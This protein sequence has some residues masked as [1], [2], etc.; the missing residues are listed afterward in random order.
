MARQDPHDGWTP[1]VQTEEQP[2]NPAVN[3]DPV[4]DD[5]VV[6]D[7]I[8]ERPELNALIEDYATARAV[9]ESVSD[10]EKRLR[11]TEGRAEQA[12]FDGLERLGLRSARHKTLGLFTLNDM[13]NG[14][15]IDAAKLRE[16]ALEEMPELLSPHASKLGKIVRDALKEG[17]PLPPGVEATFYRKINWRRGPV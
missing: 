14:S 7:H 13:A 17:E 10:E 12:L 1:E 4:S 5:G 3:G 11:A 15:V 8:P 2:G 6:D 16:W 9:R